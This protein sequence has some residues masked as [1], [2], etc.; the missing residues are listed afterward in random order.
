MAVTFCSNFSGEDSGD[1]DVGG[2]RVARML[3]GDVGRRGV[4]GTL[5]RD[6]EGS[7]VAETPSDVKRDIALDVCNSC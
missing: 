4:C 3:G 6:V 2:S 1:G 5:R 7:G